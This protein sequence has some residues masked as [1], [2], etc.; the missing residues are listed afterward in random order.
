[1]P[2]LTR[3]FLAVPAAALLAACS[4]SKEGGTGV[5]VV[6]VTPAAAALCIGDTLTFTAHLLDASG[7]TV[8]GSGVRWSSSDTQAVSVDSVTGLAHALALGTAQI[9]ASVGGLRSATP[10]RLDVPLDLVPEFVPDTV[11]LAP[12]DTFTLGV[13]LRRASS[14]PV[15]N[16]TPAI[17]PL[18]T[19]PASI[20]ASGLVTAKAAGTASL[21]LSG[22]GFIGHGAARVYTPPDPATG[23]GYLWGSGPIELRV[24][25]GT[26]LVNFT[27]LSGKPAYELYGTTAANARQFAYEDTLRLAGTGTFALDSL[28]SSEVSNA[29]TCNPPRPFVVYGDNA[30]F[31]TLLSMHGGSTRVTTYSTTGLRMASGRVTTR[32]RGIVGAVG[33][34]LDTLQA[35]FTFSAPLRDSTGVCP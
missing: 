4:G 9:T 25:M 16:R 10:G 7:D 19:A 14:G 13:R 26:V 30:S 2:P 8:T 20:T 22:C 1:M 29:L 35:I 33:T 15:P 6:T 24:S 23:L 27:L 21:S 3:A 32:M 12:G 11:I 18:D 5:A 17:E 31:T 34:T 28:L